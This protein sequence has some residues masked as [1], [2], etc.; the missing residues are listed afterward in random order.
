MSCIR[1]VAKI[2]PGSKAASSISALVS[3]PDSEQCT[4]S[5]IHALPLMSSFVLHNGGLLARCLSALKSWVAGMRS[6]V[7]T[8]GWTSVP[9][10]VCALLYGYSQTAVL[11]DQM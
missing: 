11:P 9:S 4:G 6:A 7:C 2:K 10:L 8:E 5:H 3:A 1:K